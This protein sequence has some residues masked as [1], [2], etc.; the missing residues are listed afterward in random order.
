MTFTT[1]LI[2]TCTVERFTNSGDT[3]FGNPTKVWADHLT[4]QACRLS[5]ASG[6]ESQGSTESTQVDEVLFMQD[7]DVTEADRVTVDS[8]LYEIVFVTDKQDSD[9]NHH[10]ELGLVR[11]KA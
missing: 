3:N 2:N 1:L 9:N 8:V 7:V 4:A 6:R 11:V 5:D 10:K